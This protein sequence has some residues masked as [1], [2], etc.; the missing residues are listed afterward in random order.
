MTGFMKKVNRMRASEVVV[1]A[2]PPAKSIMGVPLLSTVNPKR[3]S[4]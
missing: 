3:Y 4:D 1:E 2:S